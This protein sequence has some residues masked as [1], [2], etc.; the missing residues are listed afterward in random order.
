MKALTVLGLRPASELGFVLVHEHLLTNPPE[1]FI[2]KDPDLL[3]DDISRSME[4]LKILAS[5]GIKTL[6][7]GTPI[8]YGRNV[9]GIV[10]IARC[11]PEVNIIAVTG[12]YTAETLDERFLAMNVDELSRI[13]VKEIREGM[14]NTN[15]RAGLI[16]VAASYNT[17]AP[18][19]EKIII[20]AGKSSI[21]TGAP[22]QVHTTYGTMGL[23]I[24]EMLRRE[25]VDPKKI[26]FLHM[27]QN[28]DM[29]LFRKILASESYISFD[30]FTRIMH[31]PDEL[32][33]KYLNK[34]IEEGY[35]DQLLIS[36]DMARRSYFKSYGGWIGLDYVPRVLIPRLRENGWDEKLI[37]KIFVDNTR[38]Y[39]SFVK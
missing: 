28:L 21:E 35:E 11:I 5:A 18:I 4:E 20:A 38:K 15:H 24:V 36:T 22:I 19:E 12:F 2:S 39:L 31:A 10:K 37:R 32:R 29:W 14:E 9:E 17:I 26:L 34:L 16:K 3:L 6:V 13:M 30:K 23:E 7:E 25:G 8:G 1:K 27:D 33:I